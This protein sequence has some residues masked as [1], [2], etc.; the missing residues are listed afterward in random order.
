MPVELAQYYRISASGGVNHALPNFREVKDD[1]YDHVENGTVR[2]GVVCTRPGIEWI[3]EFYPFDSI[4][5]RALQFGKIQGSGYYGFARGALFVYAIDGHLFGLVPATGQIVNLNPSPVAPF[6][7]TADFVYFEQ[8]GDAILARSPHAATVIIEGRSSRYAIVGEV[9]PGLMMADGWGFLAAVDPDR[10]RL[11]ISDHEMNPFPGVTPFTFN[12]TADYYLGARSFTV[13]RRIGRITGM[14]FIPWASTDTGVGPLA[15]FGETGV[16]SYDLSAPRSEWAAR[17]I[18]SIILNKTGGVGHKAMTEWGNDLWFSDQFG[19]IRQLRTASTD[20]ATRRVR[21]TDKRVFRYYTDDKDDPS[22]RR[23]RNAVVFDNRIFTTILPQV[24]WIEDEKQDRFSVYHQAMLVWE[25]DV[26]ATT[27]LTSERDIWA[28]LWTGIRPAMLDVGL[29]SESEDDSGEEWCVALSVDSDGR[30]RFYRITKSATDDTAP[31]RDVPR[32]K[33][34]KMTVVGGAHEFGAPFARKSID[35]ALLHLSD[36]RGKLDFEARAVPDRRP[37]A[38]PWFE[39]RDAS[40]QCLQLGCTLAEAMPDNMV[41][42]KSTVFDSKASGPEGA[43][44]TSFYT[45]A[46]IFILDGHA[47]IDSFAIDPKRSGKMD[48]RHN[49]KCDYP[50]VDCRACSYPLVSYDALTTPPD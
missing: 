44:A 38:L 37:D 46:P 33:R 24:R 8:R 2:G 31:W 17:D 21:H 23:W 42:I 39:T 14:S 5:Q 4:D 43:K 9:P 3:P 1:E 13:P 27:D 25:G 45:F 6:S 35:E 30:N 41:P 19:R 36:M 15:V 12:A 47:C 34:I 22:L 20:E 49:L 10:R 40:T 48:T 29:V 11:R 7:R 16:V 18:S 26:T 50:E 28:G 32:R